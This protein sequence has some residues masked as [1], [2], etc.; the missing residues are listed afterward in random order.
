MKSRFP[1]AKLVLSG[2]FAALICVLTSLVPIPLGHGFAHP[3]DAF[4]LLA[5]CALGPWAGFLAA[6]VGSML[7][8]LFLGY[9][10][11]APATFLIKGLMAVCASLIL[12]NTMKRTSIALLSV[13]LAAV[14]G[15]CVMVAGYFSFEW[16]FFGLSVAVADVAGNVLQGVFGA[17]VGTALITVLSKTSLLR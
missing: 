10:V 6:G 9:A 15:E 2:V 4:V 13:L 16:I 3:G 12:K 8:D 17:V 7:A 14:I 1:V 11:Y 5:G